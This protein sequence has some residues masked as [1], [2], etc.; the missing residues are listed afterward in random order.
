MDTPGLPPAHLPRCSIELLGPDVCPL[1]AEVAIGRRLGK[2]GSPAHYCLDNE[3]PD[4]WRSEA[5]ATA[6]AGN[7]L[8]NIV[9]VVRIGTPDQ[10]AG[11]SE[12]MTH[13]RGHLGSAWVEQCGFDIDGAAGVQHRQERTS[14][15]LPDDPGIACEQPRCA[16]LPLLDAPPF[17]TASSCTNTQASA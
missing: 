9:E 13:F 10:Q 5:V 3:D 14:G 1:Q 2:Q 8:D 11:R 6:D 4:L 17:A 15:F 16:A 7:I 12:L